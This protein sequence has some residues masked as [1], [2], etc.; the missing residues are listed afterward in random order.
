MPQ[1]QSV[2]G[3]CLGCKQKRLM[4][5]VQSKTTKNGRYMLA[6]KCSECNRKIS[7]FV[8]SK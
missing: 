5:E 7:K 1:T 2:M 8:S 6:G 3:Y 4:L